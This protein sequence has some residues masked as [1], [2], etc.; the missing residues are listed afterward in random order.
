[1]DSQF[2]QS[3]IV[4]FQREANEAGN[5]HGI[6]IFIAKRLLALHN[7]NLSSG[8]SSTGANCIFMD[9][10]I[11][12]DDAR[13]AS[14]ENA[15]TIDDLEAAR[16]VGGSRD[17]NALVGNKINLLESIALERHA[18]L[19]GPSA[20]SEMPKSSLAPV[21]NDHVAEVDCTEKA[22]PIVLA[23]TVEDD[24]L[25]ILIVDDSALTRKILSKVM[26]SLGHIC[27][28][29]EDGSVAVELMRKALEAGRPYD[30]VLMDNV[31]IHFA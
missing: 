28:E 11:S 9:L 7:G 3:D 4:M 30:V 24:P 20:H 14:Y 25:H 13:G 26:V 27:T 29:A 5:S 18:P 12:L 1:M 23:R 22:A 6:G 16:G 2:M 19:R 8:M 31:S 10:P 17:G 21:I 15:Q